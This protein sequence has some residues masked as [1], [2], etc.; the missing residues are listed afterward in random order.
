[1]QL[2]LSAE[3]GRVATSIL[4]LDLLLERVTR[5]VLDTYAHVYEVSHV[6]IWRQSDVG[7]R[8]ECL[9]TSGQ[10]TALRPMHAGVETLVGHTLATGV[11]Q[12]GAT[13]D[14]LT[15][16]AIPMRI[17]ERVTGALELHCSRSEVIGADDVEA[18][19]SLGDQISV[20]IENAHL[21]AV[22]RE[23]VERLSRLDDLRIASLGI[24]SRELATELNTIIGFSRLMLKGAD[25]PLT[26][27]QR[28]DTGAIYQSG[29]KLLGL[30][31]NVITLAELESG[32]RQ[33][34]QGRI[35]LEAILQEA[36]A[37][38]RQRA[39][40]VRVQCVVQGD[41]PSI[42]GDRTL[43]RQALVSLVAAS[44]DQSQQG[45][46]P[47]EA[48]AG[49]RGEDRVQIRIGRAPLQS[50]PAERRE[51]HGYDVEQMEV[52]IALARRII[53]LHGGEMRLSFDVEDG[54]SSLIALPVDGPRERETLE[55]L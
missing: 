25:G 21:Y 15:R 28:A 55:S 26:D 8:A 52:G 20:A 23:A 11:L 41:L 27:L 29:Y 49:N 48:I 54:L 13:D 47:V 12:T 9:A 19:Q 2:K 5:L 43:L 22:E 6:A 37:A 24:G 7:D 14:G 40:D 33:V 44:V 53:A 30:I 18:L 51:S 45:A 1:M 10:G 39:V 42:L 34:V 38:A 36:I 31:D 50:S 32:S 4:D 16:I 3:V 35:E 17:G 46:V